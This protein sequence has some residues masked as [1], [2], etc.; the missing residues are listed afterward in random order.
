M[1]QVRFKFFEDG[2]I[3][4]QIIFQIRIKQLFIKIQD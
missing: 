2:L 3:P 4:Y 1:A